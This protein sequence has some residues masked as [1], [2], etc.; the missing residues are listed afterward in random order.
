MD[1]DEPIGIV[2]LRDLMDTMAEMVQSG[3]PAS[4]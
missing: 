4:A 2:S 1:M 3:E